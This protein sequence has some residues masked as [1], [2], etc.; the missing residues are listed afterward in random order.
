MYDP[1]VLFQDRTPPAPKDAP[2]TPEDRPVLHYTEE[3]AYHLDPRR[4]R[5]AAVERK[6]LEQAERWKNKG[7]HRGRGRR[8][9]RE[10][11]PDYAAYVLWCN[12]RGLK[13]QPVAPLAYGD[14]K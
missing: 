14:G 1:R 11:R 2:R 7:K 10:K 3:Q 5:L 4:Q 8:K 13:P 9:Q 12:A 6:A